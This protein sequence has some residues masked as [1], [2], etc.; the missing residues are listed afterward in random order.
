MLQSI[1]VKNF[2]I[3][4]NISIDFNEGFTA[5][6][7][8]TGA[9]KSLIMR[10]L[11]IIC[12]G[13][14][15]KEMIGKNA[16]Y[17]FVEACIYL[18]DSEIAE[19]NN[20]IVTREIYENGKNLCKV[21]GRLVTVSKLKDIMKNIIDIHG[22]NENQNL[23]DVSNHIV[24]LDNYF[25]EET[26]KLKSE[27][28]KLYDKYINILDDLNRSYGDEKEKQ[29]TLDLLQYQLNEINSANLNEDE[30]IKLE[31][32]KKKLQNSE[33]IYENLSISYDKLENNILDG[34]D[35]VNSLL[36]KIENYSEDYKEKYNKI[37]NIY[38][39][40]KD[41][42]CD[43]YELKENISFDEERLNEIE[44]RLDTIS[45]LKRKYGNNILEILNYRKDIE[46][47][48]NKIK[49]LEEYV[50]NKKKELN[51]IDNK[52]YN[53]AL[54]L[55]NVRKEAIIHLESSINNELTQL[56]MKDAKFKVD[57]KFDSNRKYNKNGLNDVKFMISTNL[58]ED[59]KPFTK[60]ASGG[61]ISRI[62]LAIKVVFSN[63]DKIPIIAFDEIDTG[64]S[65][66]A[67]NKVSN[68]IKEFSKTHQVICVTHLAVVAA[69][70]DYNYYIEKNIVDNKTKTSIK[71]LNYDDTIKE[72][73]R[74]STGIINDVSI[75]HAKTL[76]NDIYNIKKIS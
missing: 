15:S 46:D 5:I 33:K 52:M 68:K 62:M 43:M 47:R 74:I 65:G 24:Y 13:R 38:Y 59:F 67:A 25:Y 54:E 16:D 55:N 35:D 50:I 18:P 12:G 56:E 40:L 31:E 76:K 64:I 8:E 7:G 23:L 27:Y 63:I 66:S 71:L 41:I 45:N 73:A 48:I 1:T 36:S 11:S 60:I 69:K 9:G 61:E 51:E 58:G 20:I 70:A 29:R 42:S 49:D 28:E 57:I 39:E 3:I 44:E 2:A 14:F 19:D 53:I 32:E 17:S 37:Q 22:Q 26:F 10:A 4:D 30:E 72:I 6:T 75:A 21:N 34:L